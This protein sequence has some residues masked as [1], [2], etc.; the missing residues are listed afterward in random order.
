MTVRF[1]IVLASLLAL[2]VSCISAL[3]QDA[4][5]QETH[6]Q[7]TPDQDASERA[8]PDDGTAPGGTDETTKPQAQ[9]PA[10]DDM[11]DSAAGA[12]TSA[13]SDTAA[14]AGAP[15]APP[16]VAGPPAAS[17]PLSALASAI[18]DG[19]EAAASK[20][21]DERTVLERDAIAAFYQARA[22]AALWAGES[23]PLQQAKD[24]AAALGDANSYGL[25]ASDFAIPSLDA[26]NSD[27]AALAAT[28]LTLT[29]SALLYAR[30][31]RGGRIMEPADMLNSNL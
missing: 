25:E 11:K 22:Y 16:A 19:I 30:Y 27:P 21:G 4:L 28:E 2:S 1:N 18:K 12:N 23:G 17:A 5:A 13:P 7:V 20:P 8:G 3:V 15:Q 10:H 26:G 29:R 14:G 24:V 31:A 6:A 9:Q